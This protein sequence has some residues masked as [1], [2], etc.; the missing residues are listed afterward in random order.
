M[1]IFSYGLWNEGDEIFPTQ[2]SCKFFTLLVLQIIANQSLDLSS[3]S[4]HVSSFK[5][6]LKMDIIVDTTHI[7]F[8][9]VIQ[10]YLFKLF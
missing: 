9:V 3:P 7:L 5:K 8:K 6:K 1:E 2:Y 4:T 10:E